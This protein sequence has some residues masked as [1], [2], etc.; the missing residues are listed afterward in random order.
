METAVDVL[1]RRLLV[2]AM[3]GRSRTSCGLTVG[4]GGPSSVLEVAYTDVRT[5]L[6]ESP[7]GTGPGGA[8]ES[9]RVGVHGPSQRCLPTVMWRLVDGLE[10][11]AGPRPGPDGLR[12][13]RLRAQAVPGRLRRQRLPHQLQGRRATPGAA[14]PVRITDIVRTR[15]IVPMVRPGA[16]AAHGTPVSAPGPR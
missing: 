13:H 9:W 12:P 5:R 11:A 1:K 10:P 3:A 2:M 6:H 8:S 7:F 4:H 14:R 16:S 15:A